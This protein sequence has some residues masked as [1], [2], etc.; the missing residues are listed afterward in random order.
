M[1]ATYPKLVWNSLIDIASFVS[2]IIFMS[3]NLGSDAAVE[4]WI[5]PDEE[6]KETDWPLDPDSDKLLYAILG[7]YALMWF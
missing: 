3:I 5:L 4:W 7:L 2:L 1:M 6:K